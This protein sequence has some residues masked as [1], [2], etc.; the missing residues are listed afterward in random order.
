ML[1]SNIT[2][3]DRFN[4]LPPRGAGEGCTPLSPENF[5]GKYKGGVPWEFFGAGIQG[6]KMD[7]PLGFSF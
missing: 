6:V 2:L 7:R 1:Y 5:L 3:R 4:P